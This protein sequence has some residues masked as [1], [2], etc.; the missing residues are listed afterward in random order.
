MPNVDFGYICPVEVRKD[1]NKEIQDRI[2]SK[3]AGVYESSCLIYDELVRAG[4]KHLAPYVVINSNIRRTDFFAD[5]AGLSHF[6]TL[7]KEAHSQDE[8]REIAEIIDDK[9]KDDQ[10]KFKDLKFDKN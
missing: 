6:L 9:F 1:D 10:K 4:L 7:R 3:I 2:K 5:F 8:I